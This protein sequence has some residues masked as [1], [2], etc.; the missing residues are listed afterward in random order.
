MAFLP[1]TDFGDSGRHNRVMD[2]PPTSVHQRVPIVLGSK[3]DVE[4]NRNL[5]IPGVGSVF[6]RRPQTTS[7][8]NQMWV[9]S[10]RNSLRLASSKKG[11][12]LFGKLPYG[13]ESGHMIL[14]VP[15][16]PSLRGD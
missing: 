6:D 2:I 1:L 5:S 16:G 4:E 3:E 10:G 12:Q 14:A 13:T 11:F 8:V 15:K 9:L 7:W